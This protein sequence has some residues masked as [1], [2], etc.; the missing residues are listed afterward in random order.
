[1]RKTAYLAAIM[2]AIVGGA[3]RKETARPAA[4][5]NA[6]NRVAVR[7]VQLFY[8][9][10][11]MTLAPEA[12]SVALPENVAGAMALTIR[13]L[14]KGSANSGVPPLFP[15]DTVV[16]GAYLLPDGSAF[17]DLGGATL[18]AGWNTGGHQELM[19]INSLVTTVTANFPQ[20]KRV[21]LLV[22]GAPVETL[23]G[24]IAI[25]R[26]LTPVTVVT[27]RAHR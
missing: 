23:A 14:M 24:H 8:E 11:Q 27:D 10:P 18:T 20:A 5:L 6:Q 15:A 13:E 2:L 22:N 3:C 26:G 21:R 7:T 25:D 12:R 4:N 1:M 9:S 19:A 17:V 16:R